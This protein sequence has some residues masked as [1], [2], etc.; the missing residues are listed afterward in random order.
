MT[1]HVKLF[2]RTLGFTELDHT[3]LEVIEWTLY[4]AAVLFVVG[5]EVMPQGVLRKCKHPMIMQRNGPRY[6]AQ[7]FRIAEDDDPI[8]CTCKSNIQTTGIVKK[9]DSLMLVAPDAAENNV[10]LLSSLEGIDTRDFD[11]LV[12]FLLHCAVELHII[13]NVRPL[14]FVGGDDTNLLRG[15]TG[16]EELGY[17]FLDVGGFRPLNKVRHDYTKESGNAPIEEGSTTRRNLFL[18]EVLVEEHRR[19]WHGPWEIHVLPQTLRSRDAILKSPLIEH[20]GREFRQ[21]GMHAVLNLQANGT[22]AEHNQ[23]LKKGLSEP[24][25]SGFLVHN[26]G[27]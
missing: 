10:V 23:T 7:D 12:Q 24:G 20:I 18:P 14:A 2:Q 11:L 26:D 9:P 5:Q 15:N 13:D 1:I 19:V 21:A 4:Q 6:L 16:L 8:L 22:V 3:G 25:A 27:T 17:G